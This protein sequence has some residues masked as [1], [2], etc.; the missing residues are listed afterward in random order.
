MPVLDE[1]ANCVEGEEYVLLDRHL[2][3]AAVQLLLRDLC[4][5]RSVRADLLSPEFRLV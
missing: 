3:L 1:F 2:C 4:Q 5:R